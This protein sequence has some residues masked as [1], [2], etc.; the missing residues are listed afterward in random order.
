L[1]FTNN[2]AV[3]SDEEISRA[4]P[5]AL[6]ALLWLFSYT[7]RAT[8]S[9]VT[10]FTF[11]TFSKLQIANLHVVTILFPETQSLPIKKSVNPKCPSDLITNESAL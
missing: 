6:K 5:V 3:R 2:H 8:A 9:A 7:A 1:S 11:S 4:G 10:R